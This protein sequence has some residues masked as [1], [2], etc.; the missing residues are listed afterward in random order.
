MRTF[1]HSS[2]KHLND[3]EDLK[4]Y[5]YKLIDFGTALGVDDSVA[6]KEMVTTSNNRDMGTGTPP[7]MSPEMFKEPGRAMYATDLWPLGISMFELVTEYLPFQ[8]DSGL[9]WSVAIAG[10]INAASPDVLDHLDESRRP[11][12]DHN[13]AKVISKFFQEESRRKIPKSR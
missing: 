10:D 8:A 6:K 2:P 1:Q 3:D 4:E 11:V 9:L 13:V 5:S 12:F 7:Y